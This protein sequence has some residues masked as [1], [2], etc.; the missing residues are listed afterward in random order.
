MSQ[1][2]VA[3]GKVFAIDGVEREVMRVESRASEGFPVVM[4]N[5]GATYNDASAQVTVPVSLSYG[6]N[7]LTAA[8]MAL[9]SGTVANSVD[10]G[11][12][13]HVSYTEEG[14]VRTHVISATGR[15][16]PATIAVGG[17]DGSASYD[18]TRVAQKLTFEVYNAIVMRSP[19]G[20]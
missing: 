1:S 8:F 11:V 15:C 14:G 13:L 19:L 12:Q 6:N 2:F 7:Y 16:S 20:A 4:L 5:C 10:V 3:V 9:N 17:A 18:G